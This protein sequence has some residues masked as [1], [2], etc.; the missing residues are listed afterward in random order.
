MHS[1]LRLPFFATALSALAA[2]PFVR[3]QA[4]ETASVSIL[5]NFT[6]TGVVSATTGPKPIVPGAPGALDPDALRPVDRVTTDTGLPIVYSGGNGDQA[7]FSRQL[8]RRVLENAAEEY[9]TLAEQ[10][11]AALGA[12]EEKLSAAQESADELLNGANGIREK[13]ETY[14]NNASRLDLLPRLIDATTDSV[15]R[16][17][18]VAEQDDLVATQPGLAA[19]IAAL[20]LELDLYDELIS[21]YKIEIADQNAE[22]APLMASLEAKIKR[23]KQ[24]AD[25]RWELTALRE[26]QTT[27]AGATSTPYRIFLTRIERAKGIAAVETYD[28][29]LRIEP[30]Y[31]A[32]SSDETLASGVVTKA[33][34]SYTTH[35]RLAFSNFYA[36]DPLHLI[37]ADKRADLLDGEDFNTTGDL[38]TVAGT[39]YMTYKIRSTPAPVS[40]VVPT[41]RKITGHGSWIH[42]LITADGISPFAGIAPLSIKM[43]EVKYQNR[44]LFPEFSA[45]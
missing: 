11:K 34:G 14:N 38:W 24:F 13:T 40:T 44:N 31:S 27:V 45:D 37:E 41:G 10:L 35:F 3:A 26:P 21:E 6:V 5:W 7:F 18:L 12:V 22:F 25:E 32:G 20:Q 15:K 42:E 16:A 36:N 17:A 23:L 8:V 1:F 9:K 30:I 43:G 29:G 4:L 28:S 19:D 33:T 39:G 2:A